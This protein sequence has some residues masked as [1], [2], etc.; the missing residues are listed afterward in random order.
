MDLGS[1]WGLH[2]LWNVCSLKLIGFSFFGFFLSS[3]VFRN[4]YFFIYINRIKITFINKKNPMLVHRFAFCI[5]FD[6][7]LNPDDHGFS[8]GFLL[9]S[10]AFFREPKCKWFPS[11]TGNFGRLRH[12]A[13][14]D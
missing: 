14:S 1:F 6:C 11:Q 8:H 4:D 5:G 2:G 7:F 13:D 3:R 10:L 12:L 9:C